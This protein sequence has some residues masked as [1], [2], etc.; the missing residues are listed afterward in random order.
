MSF[1]IQ[2]SGTNDRQT[3]LASYRNKIRQHKTSRAHEIAQELTEKG[4]CD[5]L[6]NIVRTV[7]ETVLDETDAVFRTAYYLAKMN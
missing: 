4:R 2:C 3:A 6:A 5:F 1:K 7:S